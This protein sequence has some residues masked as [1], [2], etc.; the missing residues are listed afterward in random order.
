MLANRLEAV[1]NAHIQGLI[2]LTESDRQIWD[3]NLQILDLLFEV[4]NAVKPD[5]TASVV[6]A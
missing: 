2:D 1:R 5:D 4:E 3:I 6:A